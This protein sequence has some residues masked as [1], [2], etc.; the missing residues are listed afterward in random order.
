MSIKGMFSYTNNYEFL[1]IMDALKPI[2]KAGGKVK[3]KESEKY[4]R[5][6]VKM[7]DKFLSNDSVR[8]HIE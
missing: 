5:L 7:G 2:I 1:I 3:L 6:Y 8:A 4:S